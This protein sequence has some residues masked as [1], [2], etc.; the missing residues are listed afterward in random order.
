MCVC[1][2]VCVC[3]YMFIYTYIYIYIYTYIYI[4][5]YEMSYLYYRGFSVSGGVHVQTSGQQSV[6]RGSYVSI[7][8]HMSAYSAYAVLN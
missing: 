3:V 7:R 8:Q 4:Y 6:E 2:S 5:I 1:V